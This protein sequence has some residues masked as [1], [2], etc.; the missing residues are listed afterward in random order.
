[1][2]RTILVANRGE[3]ACRIMRTCREMGIRTVAVYSTAD[4]D[5]RHVLEADEAI[6]IGDAPPSESYL[7]IERII[8]AAHTAVAEAIHPGFG[9]LAENAD[10]A[11]ACADAGLIFIGP[12]PEAIAA[13]GNK[14][15]AKDLMVQAGVPIVPGYN[16]REQSNDILLA[17]AEK[18]GLP[19]MVKAAAGGGGKGMRLVHTAE[20]LPEA[21]ASAR[22]E[23]L[24]A[25][26]SDELTLEKALIRPRHVEFQVLGDQHGRVIHLGERDCSLQRRHQKVVEEAPAPHFSD[27]LR[28]KMGDAAVAAAQAVGYFSAGT[29][30]FLLA[31]DGAFYFLE[32]NT[33]IQVEHPVTE[34]ITGL[35]LVAWQIRIA[36]GEA[37]SLAQEDVTFNG[38]AIEV[39]LYAENPAHDYL[40]VT[41]DVALWRPPEQIRV[42]SGLKAQ[43]EITIFYDP[44]V[45]KLIAHGRDR[46]T[47]IRKLADALEKTRLVGVTTNQYFL[48]DVLLHEAFVAGEVQTG[49][50]DAYFADWAQPTG[51]VKLAL[52]AVT[53]AQYE[54]QATI[55]GQNGYWRNSPNRPQIYRYA[56]QADVQVTP[57]RPGYLIQIGAE[58]PFVIRQFGWDRTTSE[59]VIVTD[60]RRQKVTLVQAG[61]K[62]WSQTA[63]GVVAL[64]V[65]SLLPEPHPPAD[66]G[67]SLKAPMP[68]VV[69]EVLVEVGQEVEEGQALLKLEAMKMEHTIRSGADGVVQ[70]IYFTA[71]EQVIAEA[72]LLRIGQ[73]ED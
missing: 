18:I 46:A 25:F 40:P 31:E 66:A 24:Q 49:F 23:A 71:G 64:T 50:L 15:A 16:G 30:E 61:Q 17:E 55:A 22:R 21:L 65:E 48:R 20:E 70:E 13:M 27:E 56:E 7:S 44:L 14:R 1:M 45:A 41:G 68:G 51:E 42:D 38:H 5:A 53:L 28:Q 9:F 72:Q 63:Q 52:T 10:F 54:Q 11:Q 35:D 59:A 2:I 32:M 62:W 57:T 12:S 43:D 67:G 19:L 29:V 26:G 39:R 6:W 4:A 36:E 73:N 60:E 8:E 3:I 33:R 69:L 34:L 37:L 58:E 47:A